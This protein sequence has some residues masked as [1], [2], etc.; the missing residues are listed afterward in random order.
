MARCPNQ[1]GYVFYCILNSVNAVKLQT[2]EEDRTA[3]PLI[4][5]LVVQPTGFSFISYLET[6]QMDLLPLYPVTLM[7]VSIVTSGSG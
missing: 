5:L 6:V 7:E 3:A 1:S 2:V 4:V